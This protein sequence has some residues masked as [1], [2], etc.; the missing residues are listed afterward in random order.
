MKTGGVLSQGI[1]FPISILPEGNYKIG[2]DVTQLIDITQYEATMDK[3]DVC[4]NGECLPHKKYPKY[5]MRMAWFRKLVR[6]KGQDKDFPSFVSKTDGTRPQN[7]PKYS[8]CS[9]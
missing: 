2:D 1:C 3:E 6:P 4:S 5:L 8:I 9:T 7:M